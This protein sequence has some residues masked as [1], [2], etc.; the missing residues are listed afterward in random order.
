MSVYYITCARVPKQ[1]SYGIFKVKNALVRSVYVVTEYTIC[2][3]FFFSFFF[4]F[5]P[6]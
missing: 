2:R 3:V 1:K 4:F 5:L 6:P